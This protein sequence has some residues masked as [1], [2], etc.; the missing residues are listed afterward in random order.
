MKSNNK[1]NVEI[2]FVGERQLPGVSA[3]EK[4]HLRNLRYPIFYPRY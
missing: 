1:L 4:E 2:N 3:Q